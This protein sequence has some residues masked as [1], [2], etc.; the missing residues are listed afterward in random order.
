MNEKILQTNNY[1]CKNCGGTLYFNPPEQN[2]K[3]QKCLSTYPL[4]KQRTFKKHTVTTNASLN[5][6]YQE[7]KNDN[8]V[9]KCKNCG[10]SII[11]NKNEMSSTCPYCNTALTLLPEQL[12]GLKPD[13]I[14]PFQFDKTQASIKFAE[15]VKHKFFVNGAFKKKLPENK[16]WGTYIPSFNFDI[17]T[18]SNYKGVLYDIQHNTQGASTRSYKN[19]AGKLDKEY[20]DV[21]VESSNHINQVQLKDILPYDTTRAVDYNNNFILGYTVEHYTET[22]ESCE[23]IAKTSVDALIRKD[24]LNKY[25]YDGVSSLTVNTSYIKKEY[26]YIL[27]PIYKFEYTFK[28]KP[29]KTYMN[30]QTGK[31]DSNL[32]PSIPKIVMTVLLVMLFILIPIILALISD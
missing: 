3:C 21:L 10:S 6:E 14:I 29:Y 30:G 31:I 15:N 25:T 7:W 13:F 19:I 16:I 9:F 11:A 8:K 1:S 2:L 24:I 28:N 5:K 27:V 22:L 12:P 32:P 23:K 26:T 4:K 18:S 20:K 17:N